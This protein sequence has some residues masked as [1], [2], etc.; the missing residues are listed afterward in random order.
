MTLSYAC[1]KLFGYI[2]Q[3]NNYFNYFI[4]Q[5]GASGFDVTSLGNG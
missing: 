4:K 1:D 3:R 5:I 2:D